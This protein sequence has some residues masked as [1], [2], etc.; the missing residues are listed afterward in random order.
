MTEATWHLCVFLQLVIPIMGVPHSEKAARNL[1]LPL[2]DL[3]LPW[4]LEGTHVSLSSV[5]AEGRARVVLNDGTAPHFLL[6]G[7]GGACAVP[8]TFCLLGSLP[9]AKRKGQY[10]TIRRNPPGFLR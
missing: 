8:N 3:T 1:S 9:W 5:R 4:D 10:R 2:A 6:G 7:Q